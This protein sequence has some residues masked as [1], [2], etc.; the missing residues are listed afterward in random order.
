MSPF[1]SALLAAALLAAAAPAGRAADLNGAAVAARLQAAPVGSGFRMP[2]YWVWDGSVIKVGDTYHLFAARWPKGRPFP[3]DYRWHSEIVRAT[4]K[5][6][7]GP[8]TFQ[9]VVFG[10]RGSTFW[11]SN[12]A[13]NPTIHRIGDTFVL[14]Y[15]GSDDHTLQPGSKLPLRRIGFA[16]ARSITGPWTR[17]AQPLIA[18]DSNN[19]AVCV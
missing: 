1:R 4:A 8:Y 17:S 12:M 3:E 7:L 14:Y 15:I 16:T 11:D 10:K 13:H 18:E 6:P 19:P 9:E 5:N 2:G